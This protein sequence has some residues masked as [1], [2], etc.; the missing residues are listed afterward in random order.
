MLEYH[1]FQFIDFKEQARTRK[2]AAQRS[3]LSTTECERR[4]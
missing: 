4:Y 2:Q 1:P 3:A